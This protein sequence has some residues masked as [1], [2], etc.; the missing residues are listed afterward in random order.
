MDTRN[1]RPLWSAR[2]P[3][4]KQFRF[5]SIRQ[6]RNFSGGLGGG[7]KR[8]TKGQKE[9]GTFSD[10]TDVIGNSVQYY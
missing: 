1:T 9:R 10:P 4:A 5:F 3:D 2:L 6:V 8:G 7:E